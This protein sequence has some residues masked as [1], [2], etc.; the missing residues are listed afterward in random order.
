M[1]NANE[2]CSNRPF[3]DNIYDDIILMH[4]AAAFYVSKGRFYT[5]YNLQWSIISLF[6]KEILQKEKE[7]NYFLPLLPVFCSDLRILAKKAEEDDHE[8]DHE[9]Y[10]EEVANV[11]MSLYRFVLLFLIF[12]NILFFK[13][14][15]G[16]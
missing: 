3:I 12:K 8:L 15:R 5:A 11:F 10:M 7:S 2:S 6:S 9:P 16:R 1:E 14:M 13:N 4:L